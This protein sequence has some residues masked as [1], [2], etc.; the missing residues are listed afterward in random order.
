MKRVSVPY[1][2][3]STR[4]MMRSTRSQLA[5]AS[6]NS[7]NRRSFSPSVAVAARAAVLLEA[8]GVFAQR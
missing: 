1:G 7:L 5:A 4:A 6:W 3:A 8:E 2:P